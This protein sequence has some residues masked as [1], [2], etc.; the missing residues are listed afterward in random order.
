MYVCFCFVFQ[1]QEKEEWGYGYNAATQQFENLLETG[2]IDSAIVVVN[3]I[4][5]SASIASM[6]LTTECVIT[7]IPDKKYQM[8]RAQEEES[9]YVY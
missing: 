9:D 2:I 8:P 6:I 1:V 7:E 5:N 3:S 4:Q